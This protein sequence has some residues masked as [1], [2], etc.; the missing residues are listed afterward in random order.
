MEINLEVTKNFYRTYNSEKRFVLHCGSARSGKT[1]AIIQY[2][3]IKALEAEEPI[4][5]SIVRKTLP[6]IK[7]SVLRDFKEVMEALGLFNDEQ[8]NKTDLIYKFN[9]DSIIEFFSVD[10]SQKYKG[11]KRDY[12]F[13]NEATEL[14]FEEFSQLNMR[15]IEKSIL[16]W[17]PSGDCIGDILVEKRPEECDYYH[18][19]YK[20]NPFLEQTIID[21]LEALKDIDYDL[22]RIYALGEKGRSLE[23]IYPKYE[24]VDEIPEEAK[25]LAIGLD[26]GYSNDPTA[27]VEIF[28]LDNNLYI[29]ELCYETQ[30][31]NADI[32]NTLVSLDVPKNTILVAE[33]SEPK[34]NEELKRLGW[35]SL[36]PT[37]KGKDSIMN[38]IDIIKRHNIFVTSDSLNVINEFKRYKWKTNP[39]TGDI[40]NV[41][42]DRF[43]HAMDAIRY[44]ALMMLNI[45]IRGTYNITIGGKGKLQSR[46]TVL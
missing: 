44:I 36:L 19:T 10:Q 16:D 46:I 39:T 38:G 29:N 25:F 45:N 42:I 9:N 33:S 23:L 12:L 26:Y 40:I 4:I 24:L 27:I 43:N 6:S 1:Y 5:I 32:S 30:M 15:T 41:P 22:Y 2:L 35:K 13:I 17:N 20:D 34:S 21:E 3:I 8:F 31:T 14:S 18:S 28:K 7:K 37:T 11:L